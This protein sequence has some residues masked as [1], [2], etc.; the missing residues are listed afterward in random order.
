MS[1]LSDP[2][3]GG[4]Y[5]KPLEDLAAWERDYPA[6]PPLTP[7]SPH[8]APCPAA[9]QLCQQPWGGSLAHFLGWP[10]SSSQKA[11][12]IYRDVG[13][14]K[15]QV[16]NNTVVIILLTLQWTPT[17]TKQKGQGVRATPNAKR[18]IQGYSSGPVVA[19]PFP[20]PLHPAVLVPP[21]QGGARRGF[22]FSLQDIGSQQKKTLPLFILQPFILPLPPPQD[23]AAGPRAPSQKWELSAQ[24]LCVAQPP[25]TGA[26]Q[27]T[28]SV[29]QH[30]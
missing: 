25:V 10:A 18:D 19:F 12:L 21:A 27:F 14:D 20:L 8:P 11:S 2:G 5:R 3:Q 30:M 26:L 23:P 15:T 6:P 17:L 13:V 28:C 24:S 22:P 1:C 29:W 7:P 4:N 9:E 16:T